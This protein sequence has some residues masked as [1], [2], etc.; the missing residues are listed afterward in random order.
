MTVS[1]GNRPGVT[2]NGR[3]AT[4]TEAKARFV[5]NWPADPAEA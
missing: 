3:V 1:V 5:E 2:T 4:L